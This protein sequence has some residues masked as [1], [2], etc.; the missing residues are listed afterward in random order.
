MFPVDNRHVRDSLGERNV[1]RASRFKTSVD[2]EGVF[3]EGHLRE[4]SPHPVHFAISTLLA[5][6]RISTV[7]SPT[8]PETFSTSLYVYI[9]IFGLAATSTILGVKIHDEQSSVGN[10]L[11]S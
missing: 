8:K 7:K 2:S 6:L 4:H 3:L 9:L 11:S 5:F 1:D 10:V